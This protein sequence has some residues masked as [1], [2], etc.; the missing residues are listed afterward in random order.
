MNKRRINKYLQMKIKKYLEYM[1]D[2]SKMNY[3]DSSFL[4]QSLSQT[5]REEC[6]R[7]LYGK[8]IKQ[9]PLFSIFSENF[10]NKI[11]L[12]FQEITYA[13][14]DII[15]VILKRIKM[16]FFIKNSIIKN[17]NERENILDFI[18]KGGLN[19]LFNEKNQHSQNYVFEMT[20]MKA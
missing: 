2:E 19:L 11:T 13:P 14:D 5:L 4:T 1:Y 6:Y 15:N 18:L 8:I 17:H 20:K 12:S 9:H 7:E 16:I 10:Q 3:K